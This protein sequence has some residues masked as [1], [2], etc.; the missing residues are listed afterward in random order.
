MV[1][2]NG[3]WPPLTYQSRCV[4][5]HAAPNPCLVRGH[6]VGRLGSLAAFHHVKGNGLA[7]GQGL[8]PAAGD[9]TVV[10]KHVWT[11]GIFQEAEALFFIEPLHLAFD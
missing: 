11:A 4:S 3:T 8:E 6:H 10:D 9:G 2:T 5:F 7:F 1:C